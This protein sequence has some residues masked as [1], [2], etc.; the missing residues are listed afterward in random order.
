MESKLN[1]NEVEKRQISENISLRHDNCLLSNRQCIIQAMTDMKDMYRMTRF[2]NSEKKYCPP[3]GISAPHLAIEDCARQYSARRRGLIRYK[4]TKRKA[5]QIIDN[6]VETGYVKVVGDNTPRH[7]GHRMIV[8]TGDG[9]QLISTE[10]GFRKGLA[11]QTM[12]RY[13]ETVKKYT[14]RYQARISLISGGVGVAGTL[15]VV[16]LKHHFHMS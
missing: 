7:N 1:N 13:P 12:K 2:I 3:D 6:A 15:L 11:E 14:L 10:W 16:Y 8:C 4:V 9:L 5:Q